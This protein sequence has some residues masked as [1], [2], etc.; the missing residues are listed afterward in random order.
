MKIT[1]QMSAVMAIVFAAICLGFAYS[2]FAAL[3]DIA[4]PAQAADAH[5]FAWFWTGLAAVGVLIGAVSWW[6]ARTTGD[7]A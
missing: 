5:G 3:G 4:D 6:M 2:G 1:A 7:D